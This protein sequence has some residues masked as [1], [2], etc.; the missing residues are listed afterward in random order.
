[1]RWQVARRFIDRSARRPTAGRHVVGWFGQ[2]QHPSAAV[3][4]LAGRA[5]RR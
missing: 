2:V 3:T 1:L 4:G 5:G